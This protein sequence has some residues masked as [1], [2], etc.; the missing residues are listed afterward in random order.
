MPFFSYS[1]VFFWIGENIEIPNKMVQS[2]R[3]VMGDQ[4]ALYLMTEG[5][6]KSFETLDPNIYQHEIKEILTLNYLEKMHVNGI[7]ML[8]FKVPKSKGI[9]GQAL[10]LLKYYLNTQN[11]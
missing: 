2:I 1:I 8:H 4:Y 5:K 9:I 10:V 7:Q 11:E 3:L 6:L